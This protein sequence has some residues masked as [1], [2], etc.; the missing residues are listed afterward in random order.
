[1]I[2]TKKIYYNLLND[3]R[4]LSVID[5]DN[6]TDCYPNEVE[7]FPTVIFQDGE[8]TDAEF[9]DNLPTANICN[10]DIH[11]FTKSLDNYPTTSEIGIII[12]DIFRENYFICNGNR[13][14]TES[15]DI[16]HRIMNFRKE[17]LS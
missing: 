6:I 4:L 17:I 13:E 2:N 3:E 10:V 14:L 8:Q 5:D 12:G 15:D 16:K 9:S 7:Q 1:M 11:I